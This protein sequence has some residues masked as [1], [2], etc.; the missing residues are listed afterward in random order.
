[1][2]WL[3][4]FAEICKIPHTSKHEAALAAWLKAQAEAGGLAVRMDAKGNLAIDR[5]AAPGYEKRPTV[6][7]QAHMDMVPQVCPVFTFDF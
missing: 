7:L 1:M 4:Y 3:D 5:P 6:I 2:N